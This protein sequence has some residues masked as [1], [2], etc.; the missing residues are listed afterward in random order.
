M[1][2]HALSSS[3]S[4]RAKPRRT[5]SLLGV[6]C[7]HTPR[8]AWP[9]I[10]FS[11]ERKT[12]HDPRRKAHT[13]LTANYGAGARPLSRPCTPPLRLA[14]SYRNRSTHHQ[15]AACK[16]TTGRAPGHFLGLALRPCASGLASVHVWQPPC[17]ATNCCLHGCSLAPPLFGGPRP[18]KGGHSLP[19]A[20]TLYVTA[21]IYITINSTKKACQP[22]C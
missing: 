1:A 13:S 3:H 6:K 12:G 11:S 18:Q 21:E 20:A 8:E 19:H 10:L 2:F 5:T 4:F 15:A 9:L 14:S 22:F 17:A 16:G 7:S